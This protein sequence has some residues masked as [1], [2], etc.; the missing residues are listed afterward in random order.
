MS[1]IG[2]A[3][4]LVN[5]LRYWAKDRMNRGKVRSC[6]PNTVLQGYVDARGGT[7]DITIGAECTLQGLLVTEN[8]KAA[9]VIGDNVFIGSNTVLDCA[10][11][12]EIEDDVLVSYECLLLDSNNHSNDASVRRNDLPDVKYGR[13][14]NWE[15]IPSAP[16]RIRRGVWIGARSI[17]LKGVTIGEGAI[18]GAG[19]VVTKDVEAYTVAAGNPARLVKRLREPEHEA[20]GRRKNAAAP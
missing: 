9:I 13:A 4:G 14:Y 19:S 3:F 12:I 16:I 17:I 1:L 2:R 8:D 18:V 11:R 15:A 7:C 6:G 10:T 5:R 20:G